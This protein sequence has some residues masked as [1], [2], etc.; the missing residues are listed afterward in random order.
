[1]NLKISIITVVYNAVD[2]I[3]NTI[4]SVI[5]QSYENVEYIIID[6]GSTD[7]TLSIIERYRKEI[8]YFISEPDCGIYDAMNKGIRHSTGDI[9]AFMNAD[10]Y[11]ADDILKEV[12]EL[13]ND[14]QADVVYGNVKVLYD[15]GYETI[16]K[17]R[18]LEHINY[19]LPMCHQSVFAKRDLFFK[20]GMFNLKYKIAAD[21]ESIL[22]WYNKGAKFVYIDKVIANYGV[23]GISSVEVERSEKEAMEIAS[24][25]LDSEYKVQKYLPLLE[26]K[27]KLAIK[28]NSRRK[29]LKENKNRIEEHISKFLSNNRDVYIFGCGYEAVGCYKLI[30]NTKFEI[31]GYID[32]DIKKQGMNLKDIYVYSPKI[33]SKQKV[34]IIVS[35]NR[36]AQEIKKQ[37]EEIGY[38]YKEDF[39]FLEDLVEE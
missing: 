21:Y 20:Y 37:L 11:Y 18:D 5:N 12:C 28:T 22:K 24:F 33:L 14:T 32:N 26:E 27:H 25:F 1:M 31:A 34:K 7:G 23:N 19:E 6:G 9:I 36:Y 35:T 38:K 39:I 30:K 10:D 4:K 15:N 2:T 8:F 3:E 13:F 16:D 29:Y 17:A